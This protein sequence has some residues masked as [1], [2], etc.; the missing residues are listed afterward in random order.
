MYL[1][2]T[3]LLTNYCLTISMLLSNCTINGCTAKLYLKCVCVYV[4]V[5]PMTEVNSSGAELPAAMKVAPATSSLRCRRWWTRGEKDILS[6]T[7][8]QWECVMLVQQQCSYSLQCLLPRISSLAR[9]QSSHRTPTPEH[10]TCRLPADGQRH[11]GEEQYTLT[12]G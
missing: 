10:R 7:A 3:P 5:S 6:I 1:L 8:W 2:L 9:G 12:T 11:T 4:S